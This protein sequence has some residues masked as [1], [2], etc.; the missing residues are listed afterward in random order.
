MLQTYFGFTS[1]KYYPANI[2]GNIM[3]NLICFCRCIFVIRKKCHSQIKFIILNNFCEM[4]IL[5]FKEVHF[6]FI[7]FFEKL[8]LC[9]AYPIIIHAWKIGI[10]DVVFWSCCMFL[11]VFVLCYLYFVSTIT[12]DFNFSFVELKP[13]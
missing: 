6:H 2:F 4:I 3:M 11:L 8:F 1:S 9:C 7:H 12:I 10:S 13:S 5:Q